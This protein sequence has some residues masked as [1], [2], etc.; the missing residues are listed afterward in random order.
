MGG[1]LEMGDDQ[2]LEGTR[3][4]GHRS[5]NQ[6]NPTKK[7]GRGEGTGG[8]QKKVGHLTEESVAPA[9]GKRRFSGSERVGSSDLAANPFEES[10]VTK[11][12][13]AGTLVLG[14]QPISD[15]GVEE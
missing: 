8:A 4:L 2:A 9:K 15:E 7:K 1:E 13:G 6:P 11:V 5:E 12:A 3:R 10:D 14:A